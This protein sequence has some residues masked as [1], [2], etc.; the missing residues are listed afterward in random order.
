M[1]TT[2]VLEVEHRKP[3]PNLANLV[4]NRAFTLDAV[5][6]V[7]VIHECTSMDGSCTDKVKLE[8]VR[9]NAA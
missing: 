5:S 7:R 9:G 2:I 1:K 3:V 4:A 6:D 8:V